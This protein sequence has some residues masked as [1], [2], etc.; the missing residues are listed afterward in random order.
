MPLWFEGD[1]CVLFFLILAQAAAS[2]PDIEIKASVS[3][4]S[5]TISKRGDAELTVRT[6]PEGANVV[7]VRAPKANGRKTMKN[8]SA[9]V[10]AEGRIADSGVTQSDT[11]RPQ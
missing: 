3:A 7:D 1:S 11:A 9:T 8:V 4:R 10:H 5:L 2:S 6:D